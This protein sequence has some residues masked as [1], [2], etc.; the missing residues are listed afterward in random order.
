MVVKVHQHE[1][2]SLNLNSSE[3]FIEALEVELKKGLMRKIINSFTS[4]PYKSP[5]RSPHYNSVRSFAKV[6]DLNSMSH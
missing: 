4:E 1:S 3:Y 5:S 6:V 2:C